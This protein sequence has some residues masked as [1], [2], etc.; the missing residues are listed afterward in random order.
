MFT[1]DLLPS[2]SVSEPKSKEEKQASA[3]SVSDR[4]LGYIDVC[5]EEALLLCY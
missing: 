4:V 5:S 2:H 1:M 3:E